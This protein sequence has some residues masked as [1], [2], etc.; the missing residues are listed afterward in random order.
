MTKIFV[1]QGCDIQKDSIVLKSGELV[2][3]SEIG[4]F[5]TVGVMMVKVLRNQKFIFLRDLYHKRLMP[6]ILL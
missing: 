4:L 2:G 3:A 1:G 5:A 6:V